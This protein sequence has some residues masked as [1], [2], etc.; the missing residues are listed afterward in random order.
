MCISFRCLRKVPFQK[1]TV[2]CRVLRSLTFFFAIPACEN[3]QKGERED[4]KQFFLKQSC[5]LTSSKEAIIVSVTVS[6]RVKSEK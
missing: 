1:N 3:E 4:K 6:V 2:L 5:Q